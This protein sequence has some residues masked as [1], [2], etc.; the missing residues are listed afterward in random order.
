MRRVSKIFLIDLTATIESG[1]NTGIQ[2]VSKELARNLAVISDDRNVKKFL[3]VYIRT[4]IFGRIRIYPILRIPLNKS[5]HTVESIPILLK[6]R[7]WARQSTF[8]RKVIFGAAQRSTTSKLYSGFV[9][10]KFQRQGIVDATPLEPDENHLLLLLDQFWNSPSTLKLLADFKSQKKAFYVFVHDLLPITHPDYFEKSTRRHFENIVPDILRGA[11]QIFVASDYVKSEIH[12]ILSDHQLIQKVHLGSDIPDRPKDLFEH[13][14]EISGKYILQV[15]TLEPRKNHAQIL[16]WYQSNKHDE[17]L[18]IVGNPG[19]STRNLQK[20]LLK[21]IRNS[22]GKI[23]WMRNIDDDK[24]QILIEKS[25]VGVCASWV[26]GYDLPMREF[27]AKGKP[28]VASN[29]PVHRDE[30]LKPYLNFIHYF[31]LEDDQDLEM[32]VIRAKTSKRRERPKISLLTWSDA[33][34]NFAD[35]IKI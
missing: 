28:I 1:L 14:Y 6:L 13:D 7:T 25:S 30:S 29:I 12:Q 20:V 34:A 8:L 26:E 19:W 21:C 10:R 11:K 27:L 18:V 4:T 32:A 35:F 3:P 17:K 33:A 9:M 24:L 22:K 16:R 23:V 15:G 5:R 2:R 31:E